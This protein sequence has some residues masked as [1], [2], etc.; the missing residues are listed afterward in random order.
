MITTADTVVIWTVLETAQLNSAAIAEHPFAAPGPAVPILS[1]VCTAHQT[2][3][4]APPEHHT[5]S[6]LTYESATEWTRHGAVVA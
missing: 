4:F 2:A 3:A 1:T 5:V 6:G